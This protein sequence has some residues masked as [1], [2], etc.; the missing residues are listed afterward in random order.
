MLELG[1]RLGMVGLGFGRLGLRL[2]LGGL[3]LQVQVH[4]RVSEHSYLTKRL[5]NGHEVD[6][7]HGGVP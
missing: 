6:R 3:G 1:L 7:V 4:V 5:K 2:R